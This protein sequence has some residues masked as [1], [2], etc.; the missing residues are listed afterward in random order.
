MIALVF[1]QSENGVIGR[2]NDLPW[3]L[4]EDLKHFKRL[5]T[6]HTI[7]MGRRTYESIGRALPNRRSIILTTRRDFTADG[8]EVAPS[9]DAAKLL[10][11]GDEQVFVIGGAAV[12]RVALPDADRI[13]RTLIHADIEGDVTLENLDMSD[14]TVASEERHAADERHAWDYS[15]QELERITR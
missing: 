7:V 15:F 3:H 12:Y 6:G 5:T 4:P 11:A 8:C 2:N 1:A 9:W 14:W 13:Y 10:T